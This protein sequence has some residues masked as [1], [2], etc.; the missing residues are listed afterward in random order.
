MILKGGPPWGAPFR[1]FK[2]IQKGHPG[3]PWG[4]PF[5][6][7]LEYLKKVQSARAVSA[8]KIFPSSEFLFSKIVRSRGTYRSYSLDSSKL[9]PEAIPEIQIASTSMNVLSE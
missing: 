1:I 9:I 6:I 7:C 3:G 5:G 4:P 8:R 2:Y